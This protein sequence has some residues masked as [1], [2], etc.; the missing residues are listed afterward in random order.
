[1]Y[2]DSDG[3]FNKYHSWRGHMLNICS[4]FTE[5]DSHH[6]II[7]TKR[8]FEQLNSLHSENTHLAPPQS[9]PSPIKFKFLKKVKICVHWYLLKNKWSFILVISLSVSSSKYNLPWVWFSPTPARWNSVLLQHDF[10]DNNTWMYLRIYY[11]MWPVY[12][13][14]NLSS[15]EKHFDNKYG[16]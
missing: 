13:E 5:H 8:D 14:T 11:R 10:Y 9:A 2:K 15:T 12:Q 6:S 1:M 16:Y 4:V 3:H 7:V